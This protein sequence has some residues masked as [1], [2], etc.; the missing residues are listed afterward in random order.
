[1][2]N[3]IQNP[4]GE[5]GYNFTEQ[6]FVE[7]DRD[8][9]GDYQYSVKMGGYINLN[10]LNDEGNYISVEIQDLRG[11]DRRDYVDLDWE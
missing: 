6:F 10:N 7:V 5:G 8:D 4:S 2:E 3:T 11:S 1:M 9:N